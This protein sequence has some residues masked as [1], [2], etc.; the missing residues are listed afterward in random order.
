M[1][2]RG[3]GSRPVASTAPAGPA[4]R[5]RRPEAP[6]PGALRWGRGRARRSDRPQSWAGLTPPHRRRGAT[7]VSGGPYSTGPSLWSGIEHVAAVA[8]PPTDG[9]WRSFWQASRRRPRRAAGVVRRRAPRRRRGRPGGRA[10]CVAEPGQ[11]TYSNCGVFVAAWR[12]GAGHSRS[13]VPVERRTT[14]PIWA[15][16]ASSCEAVADSDIR[17]GGDVADVVGS[18]RGSPCA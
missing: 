4:R 1:G 5:R 6:R 11:C 18:P 10:R 13:P 14:G 8:G 7:I 9:R 17:L 2:W 12:W 15:A 3:G 16:V